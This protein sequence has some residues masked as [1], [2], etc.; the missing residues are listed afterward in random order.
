MQYKEQIK[1]KI[2]PFA[3]DQVPL[4]VEVMHGDSSVATGSVF[5]RFVQAYYQWMEKSYDP[6]IGDLYNSSIHSYGDVKLLNIN[7][8]PEKGNPYDRLIRLKSFRDID[9]T[10][11]SLVTFFR[12]EFMPDFPLD[13]VADRR[14]LLKR[15]K[16]IYTLKGTEAAFKVL[17]SVVFGKVAHMVYPKDDMVLQSS[18]SRW[19]VSKVIRIAVIGGSDTTVESDFSNIIGYYVVGEV[20]GNKKI[21][22]KV[23]SYFIGGTRVTDLYVDDDT[24]HPYY[25]YS[26]SFGELSAIET[27]K[28]EDAEGYQVMNASGNALRAQIK[29]SV[30]GIT[31]T[32]AGGGYDY[33]DVITFTNTNEVFA[34]IKRLSRGAIADFVIGGAG[35]GYTSGDPIYLLNTYLDVYGVNGTF[36]SG[37]VITQSGTGASATIRTID[38]NKYWV[39]DIVGSFE[40]DE[41][42]KVEY[43][44]EKAVNGTDELRIDRVVEIGSVEGTALV[45]TASV[46]GLI[47]SIEIVNGG[48]DFYTSP[49][50]YAP[51]TGTEATLYAYSEFVGA[52]EEVEIVHHGLGDDTST[53]SLPNPYPFT[54]ATATVD[55]SSTISYGGR[56]YSRKS[57]LNEDA[58]I[59][60][61]I[62]YHD[63]SY[64][65][66]VAVNPSKWVD[67]VENLMH[68]AGMRVLPNFRMDV[69]NNNVA[70]STTVITS[71]T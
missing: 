3:V 47:T 24:E 70:T 43:G 31:M 59:M 10:L 6:T 56:W 67:M 30:S 41:T 38:G 17:F 50:V 21:V 23:N 19:E 8:K 26:S 44:A 71:S 65:V 16:E 49:K 48:V 35:T 11:E 33:D 9:D 46:G 58:R 2:S 13:L 42:V 62:D 37:D 4:Y 12:S 14:K 27:I 53:V 18:A 63:W 7:L 45:K 36:A 32:E 39:S 64:F 61:S 57:N 55:I 34:K 40:T 69:I 25:E 54:N 60:D 66:S 20:T 22:G 5:G 51:T 15:I 28:I 1:K 68:P 29:G 52:I